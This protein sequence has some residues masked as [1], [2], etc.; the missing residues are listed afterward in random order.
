VANDTAC[1]QAAFHGKTAL[2]NHKLVH[3][4]LSSQENL[5]KKILHFFYMRLLRRP[6]TFLA[7]KNYQNA[8]YEPLPKYI[9]SF[10]EAVYLFLNSL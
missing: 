7:C 1:P 9:P 4:K 3:G 5:R 6:T 2:F 10:L 8:Y